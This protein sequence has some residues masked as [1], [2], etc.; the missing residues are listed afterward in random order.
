MERIN[1]QRRAVRILLLLAGREFDGVRNAEL[2]R[3]LETS[4][5]NITRDLKTLIDE[6]LVERLPTDPE[7]VRL[8]PRM[9]QVALAY[10][11][12]LD[13][14]RRRVEELEQRYTRTPQEPVDVES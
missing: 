4:A 11:R 9:V 14:V 6:G 8:G 7:K 10:Q 12:H 2:A 13:A 1:G 5:P 3:A